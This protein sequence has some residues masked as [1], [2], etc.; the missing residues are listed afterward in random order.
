MQQPGIADVARAA[1]VST[2]TV[3]R[4]VNGNYSVAAATKARVL[5]AIA[6]LGYQPNAVARSLKVTRTK[7]IG[8]I[9]SDISNMHFTAM[10][11]AIEDRV[12]A[13]G[14]NL[15]VC[16]TDGLRER[17]L[18]YLRTLMG[19]RVDA[20]IINTTGCNDPLIARDQPRGPGRSR[21]Q[22][23]AAHC[24]FQR[25][26]CRQR[27]QAGR[28]CPHPPPARARP[29]AH[30]RDQRSPRSQHR[31]RALRRVRPRHGRA[32]PDRRQGLP[33]ALRRRLQRGLRRAPE[34]RP[35]ARCAPARRP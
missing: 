26:F 9:V 6:R 28:G 31:P 23:G 35:C 7:I 30:R 2:A 32:G 18:A 24:G 20:L 29:Q 8:F 5:R 3:S 11:R 15:I 34:P 19:R 10:A 12:S 33:A 13:E 16:S 17:E 22:E 1:R 4:V 27:Q 25:R 14:Y 21:Q